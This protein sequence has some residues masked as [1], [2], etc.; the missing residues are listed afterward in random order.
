VLAGADVI[1]HRVHD[2]LVEVRHLAGLE[3]RLAKEAVDRAG[4][5]GRQKRAARSAQ[6]S[7]S[8]LAT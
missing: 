3:A 6:R 7:S 5:E 1:A 4:G 8:A 2:G